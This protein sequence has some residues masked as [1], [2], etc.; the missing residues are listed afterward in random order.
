MVVVGFFLLWAGRVPSTSPGSRG[1]RAQA[2][3]IAR[4]TVS[5][6]VV[7]DTIIDDMPA[8]AFPE[9]PPCANSFAPTSDSRSARS[10]EDKLLITVAPEGYLRCLSDRAPRRVRPSGLRR[11]PT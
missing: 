3:L 10:L 7:F 9:R 8:D 2:V 5:Y 1:V 4:R 11:C 6:V